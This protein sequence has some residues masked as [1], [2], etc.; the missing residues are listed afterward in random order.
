MIVATQPMNLQNT[1]NRKE[2]HVLGIYSL[3][4]M[5]TVFPESIFVMVTMIA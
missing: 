1:V 3:V 5:A 4:I 2:E